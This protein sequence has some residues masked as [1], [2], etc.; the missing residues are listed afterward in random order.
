MIENPKSPRV[1]RVAALA[2]KKERRT[3]GRFIVEGPQAVRELLAHRPEVAE[4]IYATTENAPW[5]I[6]LD[7]LADTAEVPVE[8]VTPQV[9][10]AM[11]ETVQPQ[12][13]LAVAQT[14]TTPPA[15]V[16]QD[17]RLVAILH[18][19]RDPGNAGTVLRAADAA[20]AD[21]VIFSGESIDAFHP[22]V[23]RSTTGSLFHLPVTAVPTLEAA[24]HVVREAGL[25]PVAADTRGMAVT[26]A[27]TQ[28]LLHG[29]LAWVFGNEAHGLS[30]SDRELIGTSVRLP[31]YGKAESLNLATAASVLLYESA[32]AQRR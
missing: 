26:D 19:I 13:I 7:R 18:E 24:V 27:E 16:L 11:A 4:V 28:H 32:F 12:G 20:G 5:H 21:A 9:L 25:T 2:R 1:K 15:E 22:K 23:V 3:T 17:A 29:R 31:L 8:R 30:P 6:E 10:A 14:W